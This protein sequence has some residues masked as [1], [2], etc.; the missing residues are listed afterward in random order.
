MTLTVAFI[1]TRLVVLM[2]WRLGNLRRMYG[3][4][5]EFIGQV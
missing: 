5:P 1:F 4:V 3:L 2:T